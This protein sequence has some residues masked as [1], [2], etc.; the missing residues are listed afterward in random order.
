MRP[1]TLLAAWCL[2]FVGAGVYAHADVVVPSTLASLLLLAFV[3]YAPLA[4]AGRELPWRVVLGLVAVAALGLVIAP[5]ALSDDLYRFLWDGRVTVHGLDPYAYPPSHPALAFLRDAHHAHVN[6]ADIPTIYPPGAQLL[7]AL[8]QLLGHGPSSPRLLALAAHVTVGWV[9]R[10]RGPVGASTAWMLNPLALSESALGGHVDVFVGLAVLAAA[11]D[12]RVGRR[13]RAVVFA[14]AAV[15]VKLVGALLIPLAVRDRRALAL[16][17][18][19]G[20]CLVVPLSRAGHGAD[21]VGGFGHYARRWG[22]NAGGYLVVEGLVTAGLEPFTERDGRLHLTFARP[23]LRSLRRGP[24]DPHAAFTAEKKPIGDVA[25]F[26]LNVAA[27][28][29]ARSLVALA[30][31]ALGLALARRV[32][33]GTVDPAHAA[34][35]LLLVVLL[36]APQLHPWYLLWLLPLE[37]ALGR[38]VV[39]LWTA[40]AFGAYA[41]LD[42]W[43]SVREWSE[44]FAFGAWQQ[45]V[46]VV[47]WVVEAWAPRWRHTSDTDVP[48]DSSRELSPTRV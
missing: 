35:A 13:L 46:V 40:L 32:G 14:L 28:L 27:S 4:L 10:R 26:E 39:L 12:L 31:L 24:L 36:L 47:A 11:L 41:P 3:P 18:V 23:L 1:S 42:A 34:R 15:A 21:E 8:A 22:G 33:R 25:T 30:V 20:A 29:L 9:L 2:A 38:R 48:A 7:F 43:W 45:L 5:V 44:P 19:L 17:V 16:G 6:H 37:L